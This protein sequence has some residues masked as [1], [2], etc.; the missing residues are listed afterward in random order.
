MEDLSDL[1]VVVDLPG[2]TS[3]SHAVVERCRTAVDQQRLERSELQHLKRTTRRSCRET[4]P[5]MR[6]AML[7]NPC[8]VSRGMR[9]R[10]AS[11]TVVSQVVKQVNK[12]IELFRQMAQLRITQMIKV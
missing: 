12:G 3:P 7:V 6:R 10:K 11:T 1:I 9:V 2:L 8:Y 5:S 4:V